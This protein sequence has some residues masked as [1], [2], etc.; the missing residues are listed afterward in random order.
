[1]TEET[2]Q[3]NEPVEDTGGLTIEKLRSF[4]GL[5]SLTDAEAEEIIR[6]LKEFSRILYEIT[7][8]VQI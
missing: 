4:P 2:I 6:D 5:G 3:E 1:M 7:P 8:S